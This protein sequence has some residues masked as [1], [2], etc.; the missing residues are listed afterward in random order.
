MSVSKKNDILMLLDRPTL[1]LFRNKRFLPT[2]VWWNAQKNP[3]PSIGKYGMFCVEKLSI[4]L[5]RISQD[6]YI[7][8][9]KIL[10]FQKFPVKVM[11]IVKVQANAIVAN[12][13]VI[14]S[15]KCAYVQL[16]QVIRK[17]YGIKENL[18]KWKISL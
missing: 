10:P 11:K 13:N 17:I 16:L 15:K 18:L 6:M 12:A 14:S 5:L 8:N 2:S 9:L 3:A 7:W 1:S 4:Y